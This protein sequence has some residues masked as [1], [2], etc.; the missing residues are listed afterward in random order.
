MSTPELSKLVLPAL[1]LPNSWVLLAILVATLLFLGY[2]TRTPRDYPLRGKLMAVAALVVAALTL[3]LAGRAAGPAMAL[4]TQADRARATYLESRPADSLA[5]YV[6]IPSTVAGVRTVDAAGPDLGGNRP[7]TRWTARVARGGL[8]VM[9][10]YHDPRNHDG[11]RVELSADS[12]LVLARDRRALGQ[13]GME[14]MRI[15]LRA[16]GGV[17]Y[18]LTRRY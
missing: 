11:W 3:V 7:T 17:E 18:E 14:R 16:P 12:M 6:P 9:R 4:A 5:A 2:L 8:E 10:F 15:Q 1:V 13:R